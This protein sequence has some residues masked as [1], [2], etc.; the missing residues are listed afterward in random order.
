MGC[1]NTNTNTNT[2]TTGRHGR[3]KHVAVA[4]GSCCRR[5]SLRQVRACSPRWSMGLW[6]CRV[7]GRGDG[8]RCRPVGAGRGRA[9]PTGFVEGAGNAEWRSGRAGGSIVG[10]TGRLRGKSPCRVDLSGHGLRGLCP[11]GP[12]R[13][14]CAAAPGPPRGGSERRLHGGFHQHQHQH[15][16]QHDGVAWRSTHRARSWPTWTVAG[17]GRVLSKEAAEVD[18]SVLASVVDG[19]LG[20]PRRGPE[21]RGRRRSG[22]AGRRRAGPVG[23]VEGVM[24]A[25]RWSGRGGG[26][27]V[28]STGRLRERSPCKDDLSGHGLRGLCPSGPRRGRCAAAPGPPRGGS[29]RGLHGGF[30]Q[31]QHQHDGVACGEGH[32]D[33]G[34]RVEAPRNGTMLQR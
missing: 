25:G 20:L 30:H 23:L 5:R 32:T 24:N 10:S 12:R 17:R 16:H 4:R 8:G 26:G 1:T 19:S 14:R 28:G 15:Q 7:S 3:R 18:V 29:E 31:H 11:S 13:G 9:R 34:E 6:G 2:N 27:I 22:G 21:R 33:A